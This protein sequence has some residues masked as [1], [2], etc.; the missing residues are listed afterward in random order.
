MRIPF[1]SASREHGAEAQR[2]DTPLPALHGSSL[3]L[4]VRVD[5][6]MSKPPRPPRATPAMNSS[7]RP[8]C[9]RSGWNSANVVFTG[10]PPF[11]GAHPAAWVLGGGGAQVSEAVA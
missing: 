10:G 7:V 1:H 3:P 11:T 9:D 4:T 6:Q 8:S 2:N 5:I